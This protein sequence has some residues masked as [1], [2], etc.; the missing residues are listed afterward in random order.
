MVGYVDLKGYDVIKRVYLFEG[1]LLILIIMGGGYREFKIVE[2]Q[3]EVRVV[4]MLER[5]EKRQNGRCFKENG[6]LVFMVN[7][8]D[9]YGVVIGEYLKYKIRKFFLLECW[10]F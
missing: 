9:R 8:I 7:I 2:K 3:K 4:L 6:E 10:R 5:E 1:F